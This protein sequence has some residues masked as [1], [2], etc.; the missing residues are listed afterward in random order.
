MSW[1]FF[2]YLKGQ[3]SSICMP[4]IEYSTYKPP[5][6]LLNKQH[7]QTIIPS[8]FRKVSGV[9]YMRE[10][11]EIFDGDFLDLDWSF[12]SHHATFGQYASKT[13]TPQNKS[14]ITNPKLA[15]LSHGLEGSS[16]RTYMKGMAKAFNQQGYDALAWNMR[17]CSGE[18]NRLERFYHHGATEDLGA[19]IE[20]VTSLNRYTEIVLV[21]FSLGGN[22]T[23]K[24]LGEQGSQILPS[25]KKAVAISSPCDLLGSVPLLQDGKINRLY[26]Q[27]FKRKIQD[28]VRIKAQKG[29]I[30]HEK[31]SKILKIKELEELT[32]NFVAPVHGFKDAEDYYIRNSSMYYLSA[33]QIPTLLLNAANDPMLSVECSPKVI[34]QSSAH[35]FLEV[36]SQ[37]GHCGFMPS[38]SFGG[39][40]WSEKRALEFILS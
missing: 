19:V 20:H 9:E 14:T 4:L 12:S 29:I 23:L 6:W 37:G 36:P 25:I 28:K 15:V 27:R 13:T 10:R 30:A 8:A 1:R 11:I 21:G 7:L 33:I 18:P 38:S 3:I 40:Y 35:V 2:R 17:G 5:R 24:Y 31:A 39:L 26:A 32:E 16:D 34:C 22:M